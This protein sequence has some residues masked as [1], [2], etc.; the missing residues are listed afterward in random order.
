[1]L[2]GMTLECD[3]GQRDP[4]RFDLAVFGRPQFDDV[5]A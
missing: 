5:S 3:P 1:M 4:I 2:S